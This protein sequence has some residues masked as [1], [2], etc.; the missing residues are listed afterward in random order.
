MKA[1]KIT[2]RLHAI[3]KDPIGPEIRLS[4]ALTDFAFVSALRSIGIGDDPMDR[5]ALRYVENRAGIEKVR[6]ER[7]IRRGK[8]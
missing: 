3:A 2:N 1:Y 8:R 7:E 6:A 4:L 5:T